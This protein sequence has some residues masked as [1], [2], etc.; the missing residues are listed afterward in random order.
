[1]VVNFTIIVTSPMME[2]R[3]AHLMARRTI[4]GDAKLQVNIH[5]LM[6]IVVNH[7]PDLKLVLSVSSGNTLWILCKLLD[8]PRLL[9]IC[10]EFTLDIP[11]Y[12]D[13]PHDMP[14]ILNPYYIGCYFIATMTFLP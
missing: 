1:M 12:I 14:H 4:E 11:Q 9:M 13:H 6:T 10:P 2:K 5:F 3:N 7:Q 8:T